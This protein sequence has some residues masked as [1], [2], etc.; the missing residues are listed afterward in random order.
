MFVEIEVRKGKE[1]LGKGIQANI[2]RYK[3]C[4]KARCRKFKIFENWIS[5]NL[6]KL[7]QIDSKKAETSYCPFC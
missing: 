5:E 4:K 6:D 2:F 7:E 3:C 1:G